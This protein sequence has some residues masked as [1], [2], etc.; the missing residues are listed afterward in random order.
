MDLLLEHGAEIDAQG[1]KYGNALQAAALKA[2]K[3]FVQ[4]LLDLH[5]EVNKASGKYGTALQAAAFSSDAETVA[6]LLEHHTNPQLEGGLYGNALNAAARHADADV[7]NHLLEQT[8]PYSM[9]DGALLQAVLFRQD[10]TVNSLLKKGASVKA[11]DDEL[12]S[13]LELLQ[14]APGEDNNS[15]FSGDEEDE[16]SD[17]PDDEDE[18]EDGDEDIDDDDGESSVGAGTDNG[19]SIADLQ[20]E[21]PSTTESKIQKYLEGAKTKIRRNPTLRRPAAI[22]RKPV[23]QSQGAPQLPSSTAQYDVYGASKPQ[24]SEQVSSAYQSLSSHWRKNSVPRNDIS[25]Q[26]A[27]SSQQASA[28]T[29]NGYAACGASPPATQAYNSYNSYAQ[30]TLLSATNTYH[31]GSPSQLPLSPYQ[32][33]GP[34]DNP[35]PPPRQPPQQVPSYQDKPLPSILRP[36]ISSQNLNNTTSPPPPAP[37]PRPQPTSNGYQSY[38]QPSPYQSPSQA[39]HSPTQ[40]HYQSSPKPQQTYFPP[41]QQQQSQYQ[42]PPAQQQAPYSSYPPQPIPSSHQQH[43]PPQPQH[44]TSY[45]GGAPYGGGLNQAQPLAQPPRPQNAQQGQS[46]DSIDFDRLQQKAQ[47]FAGRFGWK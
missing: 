30:P 24:L 14:K 32:A 29:S 43:Q 23:G 31:V 10:E 18:D 19:A 17:M 45:S 37:P 42:S 46:S 44:Q 11:R 35:A 12:G 20:L 36:S 26:G 6:L 39:Y 38:S 21:D 33:Q 41:Q 47:K 7:V 5:A 8:L 9:L 40:Q 15:D 3:D 34:Y 2:G 27:G 16:E 1:G 25:Y 13:P 22:Q 4:R 28:P